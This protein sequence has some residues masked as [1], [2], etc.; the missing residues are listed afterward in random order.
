MKTAKFQFFW[1]PVSILCDPAAATIVAQTGLSSIPTAEANFVFFA[2]SQQDN[3]MNRR[4]SLKFLAGAATLAATPLSMQAAMAQ[5]AAP[6]AGP[7]TLPP[8]G[9][10][11][12]ALEPHIDAQTMMIHHDRHHAAYVNACN[13]FSKQVPALGT[14]P[15]EQTLANPEYLP[16]QI[17]QGVKNNLGGHWNHSF[18]WQLM[19]PGGA[20]EPSG[21]L[22]SAIEG[23]W[24]DVNEF[25][26]K[27]N[28]MGGAR[29]GSGWAWLVLNKE[30]KLE[31]ISTLNQDTPIA[32]GAKAIIGVD[33]W[34][35][36]Y[37]L[38]YQNR[39]ADYLKAWW[40]TVNWDK[41]MESFKK[42]SA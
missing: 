37:Y 19:T 36:A 34:E 26:D 21:D 35:H 18:F 42:A 7:F 28:T 23:S 33:V 4:E 20:K 32:L 6:A 13:E 24:K 12:E 30:K 40:N 9:Y 38:K 8:L 1:R 39:R 27:L 41:A 10:A 2:A 14:T 17:Q 3:A 5:A 11:F 15:I 25:K 16:L 31:L 29:F 22:K